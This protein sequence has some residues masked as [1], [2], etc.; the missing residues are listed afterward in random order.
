MPGPDQS[1]TYP[2]F[3]S[4]D[5]EEAEARTLP[6]I[7]FEMCFAVNLAPYAKRIKGPNELAAAGPTIYKPGTE[8]SKWLERTGVSSTL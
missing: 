8:V 1:V 2:I 5:R 4:D 6:A 7:C 3:L